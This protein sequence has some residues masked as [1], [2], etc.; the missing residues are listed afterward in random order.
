MT[1]SYPIKQNVL[2]PPDINEKGKLHI[3]LL[4]VIR[5]YDIYIIIKEFQVLNLLPEVHQQCPGD[6]NFVV[7]DLGHLYSAKKIGFTSFNGRLFWVPPF[8]DDRC[9]SEIEL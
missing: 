3:K 2:H 7:D 6:A 5:S 8:K 1:C 9:G 4:D